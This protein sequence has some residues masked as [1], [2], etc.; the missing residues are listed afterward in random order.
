MLKNAGTFTNIP[1]PTDPG[2]C[3]IKAKVKYE[4]STVGVTST[5][6]ATYSLEFR[7]TTVSTYDYPNTVIAASGMWDTVP[8]G[9]GQ[10]RVTVSAPIYQFAGASFSF[11]LKMLQRS[12]VVAVPGTTTAFVDPETTNPVPTGEG[13]LD[14]FGVSFQ[15]EVSGTGSAGSGAGLEI[16]PLDLEIDLSRID[17]PLFAESTLSLW[18]Y[19]AVAKEW[20]KCY[21]FMGWQT[22]NNTFSSSLNSCV[23]RNHQNRQFALFV[24][25]DLLAS[26]EFESSMVATL[27][28]TMI[29][30]PNSTWSDST[31]VAATEVSDKVLDQLS[32]IAELAGFA[33]VDGG[34]AAHY[35]VPSYAFTVQVMKYPE[36]AGKLLTVETFDGDQLSAE[37]PTGITWPAMVSVGP[38]HV[39]VD[40][41]ALVTVVMSV[42]TDPYPWSKSNPD[43][44][45]TEQLVQGKARIGSAGGERVGN[46]VNVALF[47]QRTPAEGGYGAKLSF[48]KDLIAL[49]GDLIPMTYSFPAGT[50]LDHWPSLASACLTWPADA[51]GEPGSTGGNLAVPSVPADTWFSAFCNT[52]LGCT[53]PATFNIRTTLKTGTP[54]TC[55]VGHPRAVMLW[56]ESRV[57]YMAPVVVDVESNAVLVAWI[58][59]MCVC[60]IF[61]LIAWRERVAYGEAMREYEEGLLD[62]LNA[63]LI[64]PTEPDLLVEPIYGWVKKTFVTRWAV[65]FWRSIKQRWA[66][67]GML[68]PSDFCIGRAITVWPYRYIFVTYLITTLSWALGICGLLMYTGCRAIDGIDEPLPHGD[69]DAPSFT[70]GMPLVSTT[71]MPFNYDNVNVTWSTCSG[72]ILE[73]NNLPLYGIYDGLWAI[74]FTIPVALASAYVLGKHRGYLDVIRLIA[75]R[76]FRCDQTRARQLLE[77]SGM[78]ISLWILQALGKEDRA[79]ARGIRVQHESGERPGGDLSDWSQ[80]VHREKSKSANSSATYD[81]TRPGENPGFE[82][83]TPA[84][85]AAASAASKFL[86]L[87]AQAEMNR[88]LSGE[89]SSDAGYLSVDPDAEA[90][91]MM[92]ETAARSAAAAESKLNPQRGVA[93]GAMGWGND[94]ILGDVVGSG[95]GLAPADTVSLFD[96]NDMGEK[97]TVYKKEFTAEVELLR[98]CAAHYDLLSKIYMTVG[99]IFGGAVILMLVIGEHDTTW[100]AEWRERFVT[101]YIVYVLVHFFV[102]SGITLLILSGVAAWSWTPPGEKTR[103]V[104]KPTLINAFFRTGPV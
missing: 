32:N 47:E 73:Y 63:D 85:A 13:A 98:K 60:L 42:M 92:E 77:T 56:Q 96:L 55:E 91:R 7:D 45:L 18:Y 4:A 44:L 99:F 26:L 16:P 61:M 102:L 104:K 70:W 6:D 10:V 3:S 38:T 12:D 30:T 93:G 34:A 40:V 31:V 11:L 43:L 35:A 82:V 97:H 28:N 14:F 76:R 72:P 2:A 21:G 27:I 50:L 88:F 95:A 80:A 100:N 69:G 78:P 79:E 84:G 25:Q 22:S 94:S 87:G 49:N 86:G 101:G 89:Q 71:P 57:A 64:R 74:V 23:D 51:D 8:V 59:T 103:A 17:R 41:D 68:L 66:V 65:L 1:D 33:L 24:E 75:P 58:V 53:T 83:T 54:T 20:T 19:D 5:I 52:S 37:F 62:D 46:V 15:L 67:G 81:V 29:P 39:A 9:Y 90:S 48:M 36:I